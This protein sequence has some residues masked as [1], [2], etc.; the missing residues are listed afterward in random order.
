LPLPKPKQDAM[1]RHR[2]GRCRCRIWPSLANIQGS[3]LSRE[4]GKCWL[5]LYDDTRDS[6]SFP[7]LVVYKWH[8]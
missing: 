8:Q 5:W 4:Q 1:T 2:L 6:R 7:R 3:W